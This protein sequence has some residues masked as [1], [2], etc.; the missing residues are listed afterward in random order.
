M[1]KRADSACAFE[2]SDEEAGRI[3]NHKLNWFA[4]IEE[5]C[6]PLQVSSSKIYNNGKQHCMDA[7]LLT[8]PL[9]LRDELLA[10]KSHESP[11]SSSNLLPFQEQD[12]TQSWETCVRI[13]F[14]IF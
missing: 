9:Q 7:K 12:I 13:T 11:K 1:Q 8:W 3:M 6:G 2:C 4:F 14:S 10:F 5:E